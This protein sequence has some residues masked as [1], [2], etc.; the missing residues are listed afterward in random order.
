[1]TRSSFMRIILIAASAL[2]IVGVSLLTW[3]LATEDERNV[4]EVKLGL[5]KGQALEFN[6]LSLV[7]GDESEYIIKLKKS[8]TEK[9][10]L[11]L[12]F[13]E[14]E[15]KNLKNF[16]RVKILAG[17][18]T[19]FDKLLADAFNDN[20]IDLPVD[21]GIDQNTELAIVY[22]LPEEIGN[23]AKNAEARFKLVL[24]ASNE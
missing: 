14:T 22:Y 5:D 24:T 8:G 9:Y 23:E 2:I 4:I 15:D 18:R 3:M 17:D 10:E 12:D 20:N 11:N 13:V 7:P 16:A 21:F 1:M 6:D 19:V